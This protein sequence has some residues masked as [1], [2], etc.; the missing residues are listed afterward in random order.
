MLTFSLILALVLDRIFPD[1]QAYR[2]DKWLVNYCRL[3]AKRWNL[4]RFGVWPM[5]GFIVVPLLFLVG[6]VNAVFSG[7]S[8]NLLS[9]AFYTAVV[10]LC[11]GSRRLDKDIDAYIETFSASDHEQATR[12]AKTMLGSDV[13]SEPDAQIE[14]VAGSIFVLANRNFYSVIFWMVVGGPVVLVAYRVLERMASQTFASD[15]QNLKDTARQIM[16]W[17]EWI[18]A[19]LSGF[20]FLICGNFDAGLK[21]LREQTMFDVNVSA[22]NESYLQQVGMASI[23]TEEKLVDLQMVEVVKASRGLVLRALVLWIGMVALLEYWW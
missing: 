2:S 19:H 8:P 11:L 23:R 17:L 15:I 3:L 12:A 21:R 7:E 6:L 16:A 9:L 13:A 1:F 22:V 4:D 10:Y 20:A 14:Q 5:L 18:P